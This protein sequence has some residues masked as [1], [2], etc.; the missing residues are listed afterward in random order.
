VKKNEV[1]LHNFFN[2]IEMRKLGTIVLVFI[3]IAS[4][5]QDIVLTD[6]KGTIK[7]VDNSKWQL[8]GAD[9]YYKNEGN[10]GIGTTVPNSSSVLEIAS[11]NQGFLMPRL[12]TPERDA[13]INPATGLMIYNSTLNDG[14]L[15]VGTPAIPNWIGLKAQNGPSTVTGGNNVSTESTTSLLVP[16]MTLAPASGNYIVL[17]NAQLASKNKYSSNQGVALISDVYS[18][19]MNYP[20]GVAHGLVFG[21]GETLL[22][23][24]YDVTGALS[25]A[26]T[27]TLNGNGNSNALFIIRGT[28]AF[29]TGVNTTVILTNGANADNVFWVSGGAMSTGNPTTMKGTMVANNAAIALGSYT[30]LEGRMFSTAGALTMGAT[31]TISVPSAGSTINLGILSSLVMF[32]ASGAISGCATC[33]VNGDVGTGAGT[34]TAFEGINGTVY[35]AGTAES[36]PSVTTFSIYKNGSEIAYSSRSVNT[37]SAIVSLQAGVAITAGEPIEVRW[38]VDADEAS[39]THRTL[40]LVRIGN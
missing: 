27:L 35:T 30:N 18:K 37:L 8:D 25:I 19:L 20:G 14:E 4:F 34:A 10:V 38:K 1:I 36:A 24:V 33:T 28:G 22:P 21:N 9:I 6:S 5:A 40:S 2:F 12:S 7:I 3:S 26:G 13:I 15:N 16:D 32:T 23:G 11:N 29:T 31:S 39:L 17:F